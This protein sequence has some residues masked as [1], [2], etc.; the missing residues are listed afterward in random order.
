MTQ[1]R[2]TIH[3]Q[4]APQAIGSYSQAVR[5]GDTVYMSGQIPLDPR[6]C[7]WFRVIYHAEIRRVFDK[8][9]R[10]RERG[11]GSLAQCREAH[12][13]SHRHG[14]VCRR[15]LNHGDLLHCALSRAASPSALR[16]CRAGPVLKSSAFCILAEAR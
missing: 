14:A 3:T 8:S 4:N 16:S 9:R 5:V 2:K 10:S 7:S 6:R 13:V 15:Q 1:T 11:G 12:R